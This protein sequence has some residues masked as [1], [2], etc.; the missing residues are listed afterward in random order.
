M[1]ELLPQVRNDI[2]QN[3]HADESMA[4]E[5]LL[6]ICTLSASGLTLRPRLTGN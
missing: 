4:A 3:T 2:R 6:S 1:S 5:T